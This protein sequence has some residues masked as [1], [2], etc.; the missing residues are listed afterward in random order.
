MT[1]G[2]TLPADRRYAIENGPSGFDPDAPSSVC[3]KICFL[4]LMCG[5]AAGPA[6]THVM[7]TPRTHLSSAT[8]DGRLRAATFQP[9]RAG[10][11]IEAFIRR[12][13]RGEMRGPPKVLQSDGHSFSDVAAKVVSIIN[14]A[15]VAAHRDSRRRGPCTRCA[16]A[17]ISMW[18]AGQ[19]RRE[20]GLL[21]Q[22]IAIGNARLKITKRITRCAAIEVDPDTGMRDLAIPDTLLRTF[23]H[24]DCGVYARVIEGGEIQA[25]K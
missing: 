1:P 22:E 17:Q 25:G 9:R 19:R 3:P 20:F 7:T 23:D 4:M 12:F 24:A 8:A 16:S 10:L 11:A 15:S 13:M 5:R 14:L 6:A 2:Q 21:G 18:T